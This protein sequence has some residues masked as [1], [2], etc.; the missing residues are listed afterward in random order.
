MCYEFPTIFVRNYCLKISISV[1]FYYL[2]YKESL[3][4]KDKSGKAKRTDEGGDEEGN[5][6]AEVED[7]DED[8]ELNDKEEAD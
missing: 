2:D 7:N 5:D 8:E 3:K 4:K 6:I 1:F